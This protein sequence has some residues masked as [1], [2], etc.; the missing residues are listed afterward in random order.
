[1]PVLFKVFWNVV[2]IQT[3]VWYDCHDRIQCRELRARTRTLL[4]PSTQHLILY[5]IQKLEAEVSKA[6][7]A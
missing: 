7:I 5:L 1:M 4:A 2:S 6:C 3:L